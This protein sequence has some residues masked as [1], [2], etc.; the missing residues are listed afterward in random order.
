MHGALS[1]QLRVLLSASLFFAAFG[2]MGGRAVASEPSP[3]PSA[4]AEF[5]NLQAFDLERVDAAGPLQVGDSVVLR[6]RG[7]MAFEP[8]K[9]LQLHEA[10]GAESLT[11]Q[12]WAIN[13][14]DGAPAQPG[15][16]RVRATPL[17]AGKVTLPSLA[18]ARVKGES[19]A[20][21]ALAR[22]NPLT[23]EVASAIKADDPKP[24]QPADMRPP[25]SLRFPWWALALA[26]LLLV[27]LGAAV[28]V[29]YRR[30]RGKKPRPELVKPAEP[31]KPED[32]VALAA[33]AE[34]ERNGPLR[35]GEFKAHY[36]RVSEILKTY[37]GAR[38]RFDAAEST[39][40]EMINQLEEMRV[41]DDARL[42]RLES[43][44]E[45]MDLVKFTDHVPLPD[46]GQMITESARE[47]VHNTRR[48]PEIISPSPRG[49]NS[50]KGLSMGGTMR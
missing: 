3:V 43:L 27:A 36:F 18:I 7:L 25:V 2:A 6:I 31:P 39:T 30:W 15:E 23:L 29:S 34:L 24:D 19:E 46:E 5:L 16:Y 42:D 14:E 22:T 35:R 45:K 21:P 8:V 26:G 48:P 50:G 40:R 13:A 32:E 33:L 41:L 49:P 47:F 12:G 4:E 44:F 17:K 11:D 20:G 28:W 37:I 9:E 38:Y 10:P 1:R